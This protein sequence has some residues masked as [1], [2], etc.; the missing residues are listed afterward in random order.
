MLGTGDD[1]VLGI[2]RQGGK[3]RRVPG[4]AHHQ[5]AVLV[6]CFFASSSVSRETMLYW[7]CQPLCTSKKV[8]NSTISFCLS[9]SFSVVDGFSF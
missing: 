3:E 6:G 1:N 7:I 9:D 5:I 4:D 8:R 2:R